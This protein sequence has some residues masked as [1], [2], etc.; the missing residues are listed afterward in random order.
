MKSKIFTTNESQNA[1]R[2]LRHE[3]SSDSRREK[4]KRMS[5]NILLRHQSGQRNESP[6]RSLEMNKNTKLKINF[7]SNVVSFGS[8]VAKSK[9]IIFTPIVC[10]AP[11]KSEQKT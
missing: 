11:E 9:T 3:E 6:M 2:G 1:S 10:Y 7:L 4:A 5:E 8:R